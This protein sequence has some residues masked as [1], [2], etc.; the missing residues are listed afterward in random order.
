[1]KRHTAAGIVLAW[2]LLVIGGARA[3]EGMWAFWQGQTEALFQAREQM[4]RIQGW[5]EKEEEVRALQR[6]T[7]KE[8]A[9]LSGSEV[10]WMNLQGFQQAAEAQGLSVTELKPTELSESK[11]P[12]SYRLDARVEG[13]LPQIT[14]FL[15]HLPEAMLGVRIQNLQLNPQSEGQIQASLRLSLFSPDAVK[16][17]GKESP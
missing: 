4:R 7:L 16:P 11:G 1:M 15:Q 12:S 14:A 6:K 13:R 10:S 17:V 9:Q 8:F 3:A 2:G 5:I